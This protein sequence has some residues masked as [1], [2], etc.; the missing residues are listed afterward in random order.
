MRQEPKIIILL[1]LAD[2]QPPI[3][4]NGLSEA[5]FFADLWRAYHG[6]FEALARIRAQPKPTLSSGE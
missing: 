2:G 5:N 3:Q 6:N 4:C 1:D